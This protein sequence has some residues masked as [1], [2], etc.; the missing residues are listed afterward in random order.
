MVDDNQL[1]HETGRRLYGSPGAEWL[2]GDPEEA[3]LD[4]FHATDHDGDTIVFIEEWTVHSPT[5][6]IPS[7]DWILDYVEEHAYEVSVE[8][9]GWIPRTPG[10]LNYSPEV[11][12]VAEKFRT[13]LAAL[14][15][16]R[17]AKVH[18]NTWRF[19]CD[20]SDHHD[21]NPVLI[22][23]DKERQETAQRVVAKEMGDA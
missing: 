15:T 4:V 8:G 18:I 9:D 20:G 21:C 17:Q 12:A 13:D 16:W 6:H 23:I 1:D 3:A 7:A 14:I 19:R 10:N 5:Y 2:C 11:L 22:R